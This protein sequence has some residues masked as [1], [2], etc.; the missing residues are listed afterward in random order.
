MRRLAVSKKEIEQI[1]LTSSDFDFKILKN[2]VELKMIKN[3]LIPNNPYSV[4]LKLLIIGTRDGFDIPQ[5][6]R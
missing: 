5:K 3:W 4:L 2:P 1:Y 6:V